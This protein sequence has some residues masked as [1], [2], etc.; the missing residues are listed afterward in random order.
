MTSYILLKPILWL[1]ASVNLLLKML[2][3]YSTFSGKV[4]DKQRFL[5]NFDCSAHR[6][7]VILRAAPGSFSELNL[8]RFL[9]RH[10]SYEDPR[11][12]IGKDQKVTL[13][14]ID[15]KYALFAVVEDNLDVYDSR[16]GTFIY[17]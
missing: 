11:E 14:N 16:H 12:C 8:D 9:L 5:T 13:M 17:R 2:F 10:V 6:L 7:K 15:S 1:V 4:C 3:G